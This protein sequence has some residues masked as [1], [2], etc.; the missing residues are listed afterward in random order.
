MTISAVKYLTCWH[1]D[2]LCKIKQNLAQSK[3]WANSPSSLVILS[4]TGVPTSGTPRQRPMKLQGAKLNQQKSHNSIFSNIQV[5]GT[6]L[7]IQFSLM[8]PQC[9]ISKTFLGESRTHHYV[10][11][12]TR[13]HT[14]KRGVTKS[15]NIDKMNH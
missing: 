10:R 3:V 7:K 6:I 13:K 8:Q 5:L 1:G 9:P 14:A 4:R 12:A 2:W 15:R 11:S